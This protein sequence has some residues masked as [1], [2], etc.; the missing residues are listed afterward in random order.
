MVVRVRGVVCLSVFV[1]VPIC[2]M[3]VNLRAYVSFLFFEFVRLLV[4][5]RLSNLFLLVCPIYELLDAESCCPGQRVILLSLTAVARLAPTPR[6]AVGL[7]SF[8]TAP[9]SK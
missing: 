1:S 9:F 7:P 5:C 8:I 2:L 4:L 3:S 6:L